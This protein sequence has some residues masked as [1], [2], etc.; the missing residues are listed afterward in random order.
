M[1]PDVPVI[2]TFQE[3][4]IYSNSSLSFGISEP[5]RCLISKFRLN[6][7]GSLARIL[8]VTIA[9]ALSG[10]LHAAGSYTQFADTKPLRP[11]LFFMVQ[12]LG[13]LGQRTV[14]RSLGTKNLPQ[15]LRR[16]GNGLFV[17][18]WAYYTGPLLADD[19]ARGG[20]WLFEP[21]PFS[22]F[23]GLGLGSQEDGFNCWHGKWFR[24]WN[25]GRWWERGFAII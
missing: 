7:R 5:S 15:W 17:L 4:Q 9:F 14:T 2:T 22:L 11:F 12:G 1:A 21:L 3:L 19:F 16:T 25:R 24:L 20:I 23:R 13:S 10:S 18:I 8:Q 6:P